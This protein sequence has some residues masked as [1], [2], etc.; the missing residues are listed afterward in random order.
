VTEKSV[1][2]MRQQMLEAQQK[3][4]AMNRKLAARFNQAAKMQSHAEQQI[5]KLK[6]QPASPRRDHHI[7]LH[8]LRSKSAQR[9]QA[10]LQLL[11]SFNPSGGDADRFMAAN[12]GKLETLDAEMKF[13]A[14]EY[15]VHNYKPV[16]QAIEA[17]MGGR[18]APAAGSGPLSGARAASGPLSAARG[19]G[20]LNPNAA[21]P[22][23]GQARPA[24]TGPLSARA[25]SGPLS[26]PRGTGPL[27]ARAAQAGAPQQPGQPRPAGTGPLSARAAQGAAAAGPAPAASPTGDLS[28][29][30]GQ[31]VARELQKPDTRPKLDALV[32]QYH[33]ITNAIAVIRGAELGTLAV[34]P[35]EAI[36]LINKVNGQIYYMK[37]SIDALPALAPVIAFEPDG[38]DPEL[39]A[40]MNNQQQAA[41]APDA[42]PSD[43]TGKLKS[44]FNL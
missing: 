15:T 19:T 23:P 35:A 33:E 38:S 32:G 30:I 31:A 29:Q 43:F 37:R 6:A 14:L 42:A 22:Q 28:Q 7:E 5:K 12:K 16:V 3:L 1:K 27:S 44:L 2:E 36:G 4:E 26:A 39:T 21:P 41:A 24:G 8:G 17:A 18:V 10:M 34:S 13:I 11:S 40:F 25:A 9:S 20:Q